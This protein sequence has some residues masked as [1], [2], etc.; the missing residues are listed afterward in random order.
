MARDILTLNRDYLRL[1]GGLERLYEPA[2]KHCGRQARWAIT[3]EMLYK[4]SGSIASLKEF[5]RKVKMIV[6]GD[7]LPDY[8]LPYEPEA[9]QMLFHAKDGGRLAESLART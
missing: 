2:R 8:R 3:T 9:D 1:D 5:R 6:E 7:V 4:K